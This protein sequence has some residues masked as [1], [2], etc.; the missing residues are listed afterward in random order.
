MVLS[1]ADDGSDTDWDSM[2]DEGPASVA[3]EQ[4]PSDIPPSTKAREA[5][6]EQRPES[7][8][9]ATSSPR[10]QPL[11][12]PATEWANEETPLLDAGP[13]PP[14]YADVT[15]IRSDGSN[16]AAQSNRGLSLEPQSM[17][18]R[19]DHDG[20]ETA[21]SS[22]DGSRRRR[23]PSFRRKLLKIAVIVLC[24]ILIVTLAASARHDAPHNEVGHV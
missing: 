21:Q 24:L 20:G 15:A 8:Q 19:P 17:S 22:T 4:S 18:H 16:A 11:P 7:T 23:K 3:P 5:V 10:Q 14:S 9:R 12:R 2:Y 1:D 13:P 6:S